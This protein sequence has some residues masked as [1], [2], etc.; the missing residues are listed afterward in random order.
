MYRVRW[1][2][3]RGGPQELVCETLMI[4]FAVVMRHKVGDR[5]LK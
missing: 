3:D 1:G 5:M 2:D 4:A